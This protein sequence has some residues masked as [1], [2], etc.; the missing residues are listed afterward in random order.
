MSH[1]NNCITAVEYQSYPS[2]KW[3]PAQFE[4]CVVQQVSG[5]ALKQILLPYYGTL[6]NE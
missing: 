5:M 2:M 6:L 3:K 1:L 4:L